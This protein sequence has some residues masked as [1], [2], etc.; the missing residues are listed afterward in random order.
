[1]FPSRTE[2]DTDPTWQYE[3][4][5]PSQKMSL[6]QWTNFN[7]MH[8]NRENSQNTD[9]PVVVISINKA[10]SQTRRPLSLFGS[11]S[12]DEVDSNKEANALLSCIS[13]EVT[14]SPNRLSLSDSLGDDEGDSSPWRLPR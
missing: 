2:S 4:N 9:N 5:E 3:P 1:M 13:K 12:C 7:T 8:Y 6:Q 10:L 14:V 11:L